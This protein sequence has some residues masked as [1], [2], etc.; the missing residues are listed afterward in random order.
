MINL[1]EKLHTAIVIQARMDSTRLPNKTLIRIRN[2]TFLERLV[3]RLKT[4]KWNIP[5]IIATTVNEQDDAI[6]AET[7]RLKC[8]SY[9]GSE[10]D[11]LQ[12]F[13]DVALR[14]KLNYIVR[15]TADNPYTSV[16]IMQKLLEKAWSNQ[17]DYIW[18]PTLPLGITSE[19]FSTSALLK[20]D[21]LSKTNLYIREHITPIFRENEVFSMFELDSPAHMQREYRLTLDEPDDL[22][23]IKKIILNTPIEMEPVSTDYVIK[24]LDAN[25]RWVTINGHI[26]HL[27]KS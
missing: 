5:I 16:L 25:P 11:V 13:K 7:E 26:K 12:R 22:A 2:K 6:V 27:V 23:L 10:D 18:C 20:A 1:K 15:V 14:Y 21:G 24:M 9:R 17:V 19:V 4:N 3:E 8:I